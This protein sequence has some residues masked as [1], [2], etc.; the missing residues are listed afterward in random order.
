MRRRGNQAHAR[1]GV[2][3]LRDPR[4]HLSA[5]QMAALT[6]LRA[7]GHLDLQLFGADQ[8]PGGYAETSRSHLLD[9]GTAVQAVRPDFQTLQ[10]FTALTGVGLAMQS[11]HGNGQTFMG[12]LGNRSVGHGSGLKPGHDGIHALYFLNG[13]A[14]LRI[15]EVHQSAE[16]TAVIFPVDELCVFLKHLVVAPLCGLLQQMDGL[17]VVQML[18]AAASALMAS[19]ALQ[20]QVYVQSQGIKGCG[21]KL[22]RLFLDVCQSDAAH[23]ADGIGEVLVHHILVD[24]DGLEDLGAL[25][26]LD[27]GNT[28]LGSDFYNAMKY[29]AV[30]IVY[31]CVII[32]IQQPA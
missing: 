12:L 28:H 27:G 20:S 17:G 22:V 5:R 30:I 7:L 19:H 21:M 8:I 32:F 31:G 25:I 11:I 18:L 23:T 4:V 26:G 13:H 14:L 3:G 6:G 16:I 2:T 10:A 29:R 1:R 9:G 15:V 24:T